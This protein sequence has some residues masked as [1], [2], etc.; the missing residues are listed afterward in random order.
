M[1]EYKATAEG[2]GHKAAVEHLEENYEPLDRDAAIEMGIRALYK[3]TEEATE[4]SL[5]K[6]GVEIGIV[7]TDEE[8]RILP[9][10]ESE[11]YFTSAVEVED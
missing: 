8:F 2:N 7:T 3:A 1:M 10:E 6:T 9:D 4:E 5:E 11:A